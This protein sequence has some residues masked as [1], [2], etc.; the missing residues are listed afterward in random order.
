MC[1]VHVYMDWVD[2]VCSA[3]VHGC[4]W[5]MCVVHVYMDWVDHVCCAHVHGLGGLCVLCMCTWIRWIVC[6]VHVYMD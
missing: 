2:H 3:R 6:V 5:I 1:V 4:T